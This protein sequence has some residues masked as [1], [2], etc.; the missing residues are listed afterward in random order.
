MLKKSLYATAL[1]A[2]LYFTIGDR[3]PVGIFMLISLIFLA[4]FFGPRQ[5]SPWSEKFVATGQ[6]VSY[7]ASRAG[8]NAKVQFK[9]LGMAIFD[10]FASIASFIQ[11]GESRRMKK[12]PRQRT[13]WLKGDDRPQAVRSVRKKPARRAAE[14]R[15]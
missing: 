14:S 10:V 9:Q 11:D 2:A 8:Q 7:E 5:E 13:V 12:Q 15:G 4:Y 1:V 3:V 6:V